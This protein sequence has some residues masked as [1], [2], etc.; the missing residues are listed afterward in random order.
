M[1]PTLHQLFALYELQG[2]NEYIGEP[3]TILEHSV[4][5]AQLAE[6][7]G[8][9]KEVIMAA[10]FHDIGH[11]MP[12][13]PHDDMAGLGHRSHEQ[14]GAEYL[15]QFGFSE[16]LLYLVKAHVAAK[17]YLCYAQPT[18]YERL[19]EASKQTLVFQ[20][21]VMDAAEA[22]AF[23]QNPLFELSLRMRHWDEAAKQPNLPIPPLE[24]YKQL[25]YS[26]LYPQI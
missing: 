4:Q 20:G 21:G 15:A 16:R 17:R 22:A 5:S 8:H 10:L 1:Q 9:D 25:A 3:V 13:H 6:A 19:S 7:E 11:L 2:G 23:E 18:Y 26:V 12:T 14:V 24:Y